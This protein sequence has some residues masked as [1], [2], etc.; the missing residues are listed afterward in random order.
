MTRSPHFPTVDERS[1]A[2]NRRRSV[3]APMR[4]KILQFLAEHENEAYSSA[5]IAAELGCS[6]GYVNAVLPPAPRCDQ[7]M[8]DSRVKAFIE[9]HPEATL[10]KWRGGLTFKEIA[11]HVDTSP[12]S[13]SRAWMRLNLPDRSLLKMTEEERNHR[14]YERRKVRHNAYMRAWKRR[15]LEASRALVRS[16]SRRWRAKVI[17]DEVCIV[18]GATFPWTNSRE[19]G[20]R[21]KGGR[22]VCS[23]RCAAIAARHKLR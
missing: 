4:Q 15:N 19:L 14:S 16:A 1:M 6:R 5:R 7:R 18:C 11:A 9:T 22:F 8:V 21:N 17:R 10:P 20:R 2:S 3:N 13:V 23:R 12:E